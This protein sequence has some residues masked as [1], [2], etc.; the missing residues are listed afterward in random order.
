MANLIYLTME[1]NKQGLISRGCSSLDSIGNK[2]QAGKEDK[3]FILEFKNSITQHQNI[4]HLPVD[5]IK[6]IDKSSPLILSAISNNEILKLQ[7]D[8]YRT[9]QEGRQ[10]KYYSILIQGAQIINFSTRYPHSLTHN[11]SQP[12]EL[13]S[14]NYRDITCTHH[15]A[16]TSGYS[17]RENNIF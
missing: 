10:D 8:F 5:F 3:I 14:V 2:S 6:Q 1:G 9:S 13:I 17:I 15:M 11:M 4:N 12:E 7:F 16:G